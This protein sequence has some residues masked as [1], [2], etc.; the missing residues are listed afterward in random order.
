MHNKLYQ[1]Y[2][3]VSQEFG[4]SDSYGEF[5]TQAIDEGLCSDCGDALGV[6]FHIRYCEEL[7][8][9]IDWA[10]PDTLR[11]RPLLTAYCRA[12][13]ERLQQWWCVQG[14]R[15]LKGEHYVCEA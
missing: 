11:D 8:S 9:F 6:D 1:A 12:E 7:I 5:I 3:R 4:Q 2:R 13:T 15:M 14:D 10:D